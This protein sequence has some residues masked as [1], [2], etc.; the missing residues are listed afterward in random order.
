MSHILKF[1]ISIMERENKMKTV[2]LISIIKSDLYRIFGYNNK[3]IFIKSMIF[4]SWNVGAHYLIYLRLCNY[5]YINKEF[6]L[7]RV[8]NKK[9]KKMQIRYGIEIQSTTKI[10][11]ALLIPHFGGIVIHENAIIGDGC[12]IMHGVTI[13]INAF[14]SMTEVA[15]I[16]DNVVIGAGAKI[17]GN[18]KIGN[19]VTIGAN[20]VVT[21]DIPSNAV[22]GG[23]PGKIISY[24]K[25][26]TTNKY[27]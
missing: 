27:E 1:I 4:K 8:F 21:K 7:F 15:E 14:K 2:E 11:K 3:K 17:I 6:F 10:G 24:K 5:L 9:L 26:I 19:N 16:G 18:I 22:V 20:S 23:N 12:T 25:S 13:G